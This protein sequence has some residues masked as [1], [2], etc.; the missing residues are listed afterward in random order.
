[1]LT[2][3]EL[4]TL[5]D[6]AELRIIRLKME[7]YPSQEMIQQVSSAMVNARAEADRIREKQCLRQPNESLY[8]YMIRMGA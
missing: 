2:A 8:D 5:A 6:S 4:T 1:M 3:A 7:K